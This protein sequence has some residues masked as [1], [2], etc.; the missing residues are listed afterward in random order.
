MKKRYLIAGSAGLVCAALAVKLLRRPAD[1]EWAEHAGELPHADRSRFAEVD[2]V[3]VHYQE[4]GPADAPPIIL[5]H[6]FTA[7]TLVWKDVLLPLSDARFR[8]IAPDL[9][10]Y[11]YSEK[12]RRGEYT[13]DAQARMILGLMD[14]LDIEHAALVGS[15]YGGAVAATCALDHPE[16]VSRLVLISAVTNDEPVQQPMA[17][18]ARARV[19][20]D[21]ITPLMI[22]SRALS[23]W[24]QKKKIRPPDSPLIYDEERLEGHHR[25]LRA[26]SAHRAV[27]RTLRNWSACRI[28]QEAHRIHQPALLIWGENDLEI[29]L[30]HGRQ[31][32]ALMP[33]ARLVVF[34]HCGHLPQEEYPREFTEVVTDFL[35]DLKAPAQLEEASAVGA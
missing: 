18:L 15:S 3:R 32:Q 34:R 23:R 19:L 2:G 5:I 16:R 8:V 12:P 6:G 25:P 31:L 28:E 26:A 11:G 17:K 4:A 29:P 9:L 20:G 35:E 22:D 14:Q 21:L 27:L 10:G 1:V 13:I 24:R 7:S 33:D 30:R